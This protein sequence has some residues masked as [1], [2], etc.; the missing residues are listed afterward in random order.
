MF[1]VPTT[2]KE[3][4]PGNYL[5]RTTWAQPMSFQRQPSATVSGPGWCLTGLGATLAPPPSQDP[6][7]IGSR[8]CSTLS[9]APS[10]LRSD[11]PCRSHYPPRFTKG[12][13]GRGSHPLSP[14]WC[15]AEPGPEPRLSGSRTHTPDP[16]HP[17]HLGRPREGQVCA[18][19]FLKCSPDL[20]RSAGAQRTH[21]HGEDSGSRGSM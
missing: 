18:S 14:S 7:T 21:Q 20:M 4:L 3:T 5:M 8:A 15:T 19:P 1:L 2:A 17:L 13:P 16:T 9:G 12:K 10:A 6:R 11:Q